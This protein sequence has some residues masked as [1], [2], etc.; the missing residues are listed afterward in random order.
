M[1]LLRGAATF[2]LFFFVKLLVYVTTVGMAMQ[3]NAKLYMDFPMWGIGLIVLIG[4]LFLYNSLVRLFALYDAISADA[5]F[6]N[7]IVKRRFAEYRDAFCDRDLLFTTLPA[8][9]LFSILLP[10]GAFP[11]AKLLFGS[12][13]SLQYPVTYAV[14]IFSFIFTAINSRYETRRHWRALYDSR[15]TEAVRRRIIFLLKGILISVIYPF[16]V[17]LSP[18]LVV[19]AIN[20]FTVLTALLGLFSTIGLGIA[21]SLTLIFIISMPRLRALSARRKFTKRLSS[22]AERAGYEVLDMQKEKRLAAG[23]AGAIS[24]SLKYKERKY[25]CRLIPIERRGRPIYFTGEHDAHF[26]LKIGIGKH[27]VSIARH[28]DYSPTGEGKSI[29][30]LAPEPKYVFVSSDGGEKRLFTGDKIWKHTVF[31]PDSFFGALDR[32]CLDKS[33]GMFE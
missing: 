24:F 13:G 15:D 29:V 3:D 31:E 12:L 17:P 28:F 10:I 23:Y 22:V 6:E 25:T 1:Y 33:S 5:F 18:F 11:E 9:A 21:T 16:A 8:I 4:S 2:A 7:P 30:I 26:L 14:Y 32:H 19:I 20:L 27:F